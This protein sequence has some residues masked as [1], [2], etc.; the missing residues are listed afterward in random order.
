[1]ALRIRCRQIASADIDGVVNL[2]TSGFRIR[3]RDFWVRAFQRLSE[4][5][6][7]PGFPKYGYLLEA[8]GTPVGV[9]LLI[10]S[11]I[12]V[13][14]ELKIRCS[15][16]SWYVEPAFRAYGAILGSQAL[17][18]EHVTYFNI[19]TGPHTLPILEAQGFERYCDGRFVAVPA[20]SMRSKCSCLEVVTPDIC[21]DEDLPSSEIELLL[22]HARYGCISV[23]CSS[24]DGRHP[25]VFLS[26]RK[27]GAHYAYLAYCRDVEEFVRFAGPLGR[28]LAR[29]GLPLVVLDANGPI[30]ALI[31]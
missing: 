8:Q 4:H 14:G 18:H 9:V 7:V 6:T 5:A 23:A 20:L 15:M 11:S 12:V 10:F 25:F 22:A 3:S 30:N 21:A 2:L 16:S 24:A 31:G 27:A 1:M 17:K 26:L 29:R 28:F 13:N 19:T